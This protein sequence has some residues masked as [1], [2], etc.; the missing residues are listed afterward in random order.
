M[1]VLLTLPSIAALA[2]I[3]MVLLLTYAWEATFGQLL[4]ALIAVLNKV[5]IRIPH[6]RTIHV[7]APVTVF[8]QQIQNLVHRLS[9][10]AGK[11]N[12]IMW[13]AFTHH[14]AL[15]W[16]AIGE[17]ID[18]VS[19]ETARALQYLRDHKIQAL[20]TAT[21]GPLGLLVYN[22]R[23]KLAALALAI[24][25]AAAHPGRL[26]THTIE[27]VKVIEH[28][29]VKIISR[30]VP[31]AVAGAIAIPRGAIHGLE[32]DVSALQDWVKAHARQ[33]VVAGSLGLVMA[34]LAK[35]GLGWARCSKVGR[36]GRRICGMNDSLLDDLLIGSLIYASS[37]S[38]VTLARECQGFTSDVDDAVRFFVR[39]L[40]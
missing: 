34:A 16:Q 1:P 30:T 32:R 25:H 11:A 39:E 7:F 35:I 13:N 31:A 3:A 36:V 24:A 12:T 33:V 15:A 23:K 6:Y 5:T 28:R 4:D 18:L 8:L 19:R 17:S 22:E 21:T 37:I 40:H 38:V 29:T 20:I 27:R 10:I 2:I 9:A 14:L 26:V